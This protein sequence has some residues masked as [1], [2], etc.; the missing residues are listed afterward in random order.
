MMGVINTDH[1]PPIL[2]STLSLKYEG[3]FFPYI[4]LIRKN[5]NVV[6]QVLQE[7][8]RLVLPKE[9]WL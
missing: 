2:Y 3:A 9:E 4:P 5:S 7:I 6:G 8:F 1:T